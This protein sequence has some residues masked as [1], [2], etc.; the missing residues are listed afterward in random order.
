MFPPDVGQPD[1]CVVRWTQA[2]E[3][4]V[5]RCVDDIGTEL[6]GPVFRP[7]VGRLAAVGSGYLNCRSLTIR[8][9]ASNIRTKNSAS[10]RIFVGMALDGRRVHS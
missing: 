7:T 6:P 10:R 3:R 5:V 9:L 8:P 2:N 4:A 1:P